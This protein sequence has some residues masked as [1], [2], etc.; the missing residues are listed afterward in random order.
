MFMNNFFQ[1]LGSSLKTENHPTRPLAFHLLALLVLVGG[2]IGYGLYQPTQAATPIGPNFPG[3][4]F[5]YVRLVSESGRNIV[6]GDP[7]AHY[8]A[9]AP[10][11]RVV[12]SKTALDTQFPNWTQIS[13]AAYM[14]D[15]TAGT[16]GTWYDYTIGIKNK[17]DFDA[18]S[19]DYTFLWKPGYDQNGQP[20]LPTR[21]SRVAIMATVIEVAPP[22]I[23]ILGSGW[24]V[25]F[26]LGTIKITSPLEPTTWQLGE[27]QSI[28]FLMADATP[29]VYVKASICRVSLAPSCPLTEE[30]N[31]F[32]PI[33]RPAGSGSRVFTVD[34]ERVGYNPA[35]E[36]IYDDSWAEGIYI[37]L[38][39]RVGVLAFEPGYLTP[40]LQVG[41]EFISPTT[42][43][44]WRIGE[45]RNIE[46][47]V[48]YFNADEASVTYYINYK[49]SHRLIGAT[50]VG[51]NQIGSTLNHQYLVGEEGEHAG[52]T[53]LPMSD[54]RIQINL[55]PIDNIVPNGFNIFSDPFTIADALYRLEILTPA[56]AGEVWTVGETKTIQFQVIPVGANASTALAVDNRLNFS[57]AEEVIGGADSFW[58][59]FND[60]TV[61]ANTQPTQI[62]SFDWVVGTSPNGNSLPDFYP[63]KIGK[64]IVIMGKVGARV[65]VGQEYIGNNFTIANAP[66]P[67]EITLP[68]H[69]FWGDHTAI[70]L[71]TQGINAT[72]D[73]VLKGG[74]AFDDEFVLVND[75]VISEDGDHNIDW[76][77]DRRPASG[78]CGFGFFPTVIEFR[79]ATTGVVEGSSSQFN[80]EAPFLFVEPPEGTCQVYLGGTL[81][82]AYESGTTMQGEIFRDA[83][84]PDPSAIEAGD[85]DMAV[86]IRTDNI[87]EAGP[88]EKILDMSALAPTASGRTFNWDIP[89]SPVTY[90][91][92]LMFVYSKTG[93]IVLDNP[94]DPTTI[95]Y[96]TYSQSFEILPAGGAFDQQATYLSPQVDFLDNNTTS[97][98]T[99][100]GDFNSEATFDPVTADIDYEIAF[101]D[102]NG[103]ILGVDTFFGADGWWAVET[104]DSLAIYQDRDWFD[105]ITAT[106]FRVTLKSY[107]TTI[108][109]PRLYALSLGYSANLQNTV[110]LINFRDGEVHEKNISPLSPATFQMQVTPVDASDSRRLQLA[111]AVTPLDTLGNA[112]GITY[113][114]M[115][116]NLE[117]QFTGNA[118][119]PSVPF[120]LTFTPDGT[121]PLGAYRFTVTGYIIGDPTQIAT[122]NNLGRL[123]VVSPDDTSAFTLSLLSSYAYG[124]PGS[125]DASY[126]VT[127]NRDAGFTSPVTLSTSGALNSSWISI[128][129]NPVTASSATL[130]VNI[131]TDETPRTIS[132]SIVG[133]AGNITRSVP[134]TL[135]IIDPSDLITLNLTI[136]VE[137]GSVHKTN[138]P[139]YLMRL[140]QGAQRIFESNAF[141]TNATH[142]A[143]I[144]VPASRFTTGVSYAPLARST[145][146]LWA[147][148]APFTFGSQT[149]YAITFPTLLAGDLF[150][151]DPSDAD[152]FTSEIN[153]LD[154]GLVVGQYGQSGERLEDLDN[155]DYINTLDLGFIIKNWFQEFVW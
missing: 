35:G 38:T 73:V 77:V 100:L 106:Q 98:L 125:S 89:I 119:N 63:E 124:T 49:N 113:I 141:Q 147:E 30:L 11:L 4:D 14:F 86:F 121:T 81:P 37:A 6:S 72:F 29:Q 99:A 105:D 15:P 130:G 78:Y 1:Q 82:V 67:L 153:S 137:E 110:A 111:V 87:D 13:Y 54:V 126:A 150:R 140:Y 57:L 5:S 90:T 107:S 93:P 3:G 59:I 64:S 23:N 65:G 62:L 96:F 33:I 21:A 46:W 24:S 142:Q 151:D 76:Y 145:R 118:T 92:Q 47:Q 139:T 56:T 138:I 88:W 114:S 27:P 20:T 71:T 7:V 39:V 115:P 149:T 101:F 58:S 32:A 34:W 154:F 42:E 17:V 112:S 12:M 51:S 80:I 36:L 70:A 79:D 129:P 16:E 144:T 18:G 102:I 122:P 123:N 103:N 22:S 45:V 50:T 8:D 10:N 31:I 52:F 84:F 152:S 94:F 134:A 43:T 143:T 66:L 85:L 120:D 117:I 131:P 9:G 69:I 55:E 135:E 108:A 155:N 60:F 61:P 95:D 68:Q 132:F 136:P 2:F 116:T 19:S 74:P 44:V 41:S 128:L 40:A 109:K 91:A 53:G 97:T 83:D 25:D 48:P 104:G 28:N 146:H 75:L 133:T 148:A 127:I 26:A